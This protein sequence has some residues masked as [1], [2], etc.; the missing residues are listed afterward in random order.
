M[1]FR[2]PALI[3]AVCA[4]MLV[5]AGPAMAQAPTQRFGQVVKVTGAGKNNKSFTGTF[6]IAR[7]QQVGD[8]AYAVGT[9]RGKLKNRPVQRAGVKIPMAGIEPFAGAAKAKAAQTTPPI[10][11]TP[12][13]CQV[14]NLVLGPLDL[15]LLGLRVRLNQVRL[16]IEAVPSNVPTG[17]VSGGLLGDLLCGVANLLNPQAATPLGQVVQLLNGLLGLASAPTATAASRP[18]VAAG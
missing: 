15:N 16:L 13:A 8:R 5:V 7:F 12:N 14:L 6:T 4:S 10:V 2:R 17:G 18:S 9:L 11:P 3:L 1:S